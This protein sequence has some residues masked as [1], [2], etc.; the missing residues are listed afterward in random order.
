MAL[1]SGLFMLSSAAT[2]LRRRSLGPLALNCVNYL[3]RIQAMRS[4][5]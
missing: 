5:P 2:R 1:L 4:V 3:F